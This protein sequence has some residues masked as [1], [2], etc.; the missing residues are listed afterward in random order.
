MCIKVYTEAKALKNK[1]FF[2]LAPVMSLSVTLCGCVNLE[3]AQKVAFD[4]GEHAFSKQ[5]NLQ[6]GE[7]ALRKNAEGNTASADHFADKA[8]RAA[9]GQNIAPDRPGDDESRRA[10]VRLTAAFKNLNPENT[11]AVSARAQ[12]MYDCW[13]EERTQHID[14]DDIAACGQ[15]FERALVALS[16][17][18]WSRGQVSQ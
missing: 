5:L 12:V 14:A 13:V 3:A 9:T 15:Q 7:L 8:A 17:G 16:D 1:L 4:N 6:Y 11:P 10:L 18:G 2:A